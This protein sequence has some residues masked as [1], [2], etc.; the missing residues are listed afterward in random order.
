M[1]KIIKLS[2]L[3]L[4][5]SNVN[6]T[7][8]PKGNN[9]SN[10]NQG[11][12][13]VN[14]ELGLGRKQKQESKLILNEREIENII[15]ENDLATFKKVAWENVY[16]TKDEML[17]QACRYGATK[18][19]FHLI[20]EG[21]NVNYIDKVSNTPLLWAVIMQDVKVAK[22]LIEAGANVNQKDCLGRTPLYDVLGTG[23]VRLAKL[24]I[25]KGTD[26]NSKDKNNR[27]V[28]E[29]GFWMNWFILSKNNERRLKVMNYIKSV[30]E[31]KK[32]LN[33]AG[34]I[35]AGEDLDIYPV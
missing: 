18:I 25:E 12:A 4:L 28:L 17:G 20:K 8:M 29:H 9:N 19:T 11:L 24:F 2:L 6:A 13:R 7:M 23:D 35:G 34:I 14:R 33:R 16:K 26:I 5:V 22:L 32:R 27:T 15:Y 21:A 31:E 3:V 1:K 30:V 10:S